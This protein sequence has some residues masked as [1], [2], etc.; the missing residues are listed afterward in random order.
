MLLVGGFVASDAAA[1]LFDEG[2]EQDGAKRI[3]SV[4]VISQEAADQGEASIMT[5]TLTYEEGQRWTRSDPAANA[6]GY[7]ANSP[8][9]EKKC[10]NC[11]QFQ[12]SPVIPLGPCTPFPG[13]TVAAGGYCNSW[14]KK[15]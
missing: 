15:S 6:L 2:F 4:P 8:Y 11:A 5:T 7:T 3:R 1:R 12:G 10:S 13:K 9:P 14:A